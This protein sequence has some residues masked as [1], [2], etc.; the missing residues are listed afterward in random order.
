[1]LKTSST[2]LAIF[3]LLLLC[4]NL[5][6][7]LLEYTFIP[8]NRLA[9]SALSA[10]LIVLFTI[11][12]VGN[13]NKQTK[14]SVG[15]AVILPLIAFAYIAVTLISSDTG[16]PTTSGEATIIYVIHACIT[17]FC[18]MII[19][20]SCGRGKAIKIG[21]G[22]LYGILLLF[23]V[24]VFFVMVVF[25]DFSVDTVV[26]SE[27]SPNAKYLAEIIS[28]D[29]GA[30]GGATKVTVTRQNH[31]INLFV[32]ELKKDPKTIYVGHWG[33]DSG[34]TLQWESDETLYINGIKY[35]I[36]LAQEGQ[37]EPERLQQ[38][39]NKQA[40]QLETST[41]AIGRGYINASLLDECA[42]RA[43]P[44]LEFDV[45]E[46]IPN[47]TEVEIFN[48]SLNTSSS[49]RWYAITYDKHD[50]LVWVSGYSIQMIET[51][52]LVDN[53][54]AVGGGYINL[55]SLKDFPVRSGP[56][57]GDEIVGIIQNNTKVE[58]YDTYGPELSR[59]DAGVKFFDKEWYAV[60]DGA[61]DQPVW[62][63][64]SFVRLE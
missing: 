58:I 10:G 56:S 26:K 62:I 61:F 45:V 30:L 9:L 64:S 52:G 63:S 32:G 57:V 40:D 44:G 15:F 60:N 43:G 37:Q 47:G 2:P 11:I 54:S 48:T 20:F 46:K 59:K 49:Y 51:D 39:Q 42:A 29:Q 27:M 4:F 41:T 7:A 22:I 36:P 38:E 18:S 17:L 31:N 33:E 55:L 16:M 12:G 34:M 21:L 50:Q 13:R 23:A 14:A 28:N 3:L 24:I 35:I 53:S 8:F 5:L 1:M 19:F 25:S 6:I